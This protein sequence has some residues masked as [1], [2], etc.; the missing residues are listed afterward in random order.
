MQSDRYL[1]SKVINNSPVLKEASG[2]LN[3]ELLE[4]FLARYRRHERGSSERQPS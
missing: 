4:Q 2:N 1:D 3:E